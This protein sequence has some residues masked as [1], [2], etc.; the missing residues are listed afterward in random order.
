M[1]VDDMDVT[2]GSTAHCSVL[3]S[4]CPMLDVLLRVGIGLIL[5]I[6]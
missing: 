5:G 4:L 2:L 6:V 3:H 1:V